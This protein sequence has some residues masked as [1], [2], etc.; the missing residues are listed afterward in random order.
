MWNKP[1]KKQLAKIPELYSTE[2][3]PTKEKKVYMK[4]FCGAMTWYITEYS[5][6]APDGYP[7][8]AFGFVHNGAHPDCSEWGYI[9]LDELEQAR[10]PIPIVLG[11]TGKRMEMGLEVDRDMYWKPKKVKDIPELKGLAY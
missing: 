1:T 3:I 11:G 4:F 5:E 10:V 8:L 2:D 9:S 6:K 7:R